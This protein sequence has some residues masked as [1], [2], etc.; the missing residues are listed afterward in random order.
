MEKVNGIIFFLILNK[1]KK[2]FHITTT[3]TLT[4]YIIYN[5]ALMY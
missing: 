5:N 1:I 4:L 2:A 3:E